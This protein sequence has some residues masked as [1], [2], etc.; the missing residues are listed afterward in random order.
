[1]SGTVFADA[2]G[3]MGEDVNGGEFHDGG[4]ADS[5]PPPANPI[6]YYLHSSRQLAT[7]APESKSSPDVYRYNPADPTPSL[8]GPLLTPPN[9]ALDNR[10]LEVRPDVLT[11][12][13]APLAEDVEVI[14][15]VEAELFVRSSIGETDFFVR[16]CN[17]YPD[18]RSINICDGLRR[19]RPGD[20]EVQP[21]GSLRIVVDMAQTAIRFRAGHSIRIQVSSGAHPRYTRNLEAA[22][23]A[24]WRRHQNGDPPAS[25]AVDAATAL[26]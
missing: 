13:S 15:A 21:D 2:D 17:V 18:G 3:I 11:Y 14:G 26:P 22:Y 23:S 4:E 9:G 12:T 1:M 19:I 6:P 7:A 8:G 10:S 16:L 24:M 20:G 25:F 5:W